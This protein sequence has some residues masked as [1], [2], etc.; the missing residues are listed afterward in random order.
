[1]E[2]LIKANPE[3]LDLCYE[4][5]D[6]GRS[7]QREQGFLQWTE[8][9]PN[10][11]TIRDDI[12]S[13]KGYVLKLCDGTI[14]GYMCIDLEGEP[15]YDNIEGGWSSELPYAV[16]HRM[17][18]RNDLRG[19]GLSLT[20]FRLIEELCLSLGISYIRIDTDPENKLMQHVLEKNGF[21]PCGI[22]IF[23]GSGKLAYDKILL[24]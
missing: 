11:D 19:H 21:K 20:A 15:A 1:M 12:A 14:A 13:G 10:I 23:Q 22:I 8:D 3:E 5:I 6:M 7:Y 9:Y 18:F 4:I 2:A 17:A 24:T 16:V